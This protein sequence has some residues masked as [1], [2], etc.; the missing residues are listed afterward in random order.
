MGR[1]GAS[2]LIA[3]LVACSG[4]RPTICAPGETQVCWCAG[5][6]TSAQVCDDDGR[7]W[8]TCPCSDPVGDDDDD[9]EDAA[10]VRLGE[11]VVC[12][13]PAPTGP[14][15]PFVDVAGDA[16]ISFVPVTPEFDHSSPPEGIA[17]L[18]IE[19]GGGLVVADLDGDD[20]LD[21]VFTDSDAAP[22]YFRGDGQLGFDEVAAEEAGLPVGEHWLHGVS[23]ADVDADGDLDLLFLARDDNHFLWNRGDGTF[24]DATDEVELGGGVLRSCAGAWS[25]FDKDGDLDVHVANHGIGAYAHGEYFS[26]DRDGL[27]VQQA[28]GTFIDRIDEAYPYERDGYGFQGAWFDAD[29]DGWTDLYVVNDMA[30][31][32]QFVPNVF[33]RNGGPGDDGAW[34]WEYQA[35]S[36]LIVPMLAMGVGIGDMDNDMD[37]DVHVTQAGPTL[38]A[39]NDQFGE[40]HYFTDISLVVMDLMFTDAADISYSTSWFDHDND[41]WQ[42]LYTTFSHMPTKSV[43]Y[44]PSFT[45]NDPEQ[46]DG[47]W[48]WDPETE[49]YADL[50]PDLGIDDVGLT[51][52]AVV[53]DVNRDGFLDIT[54]FG[55]YSGP[56]LWISSCNANA[57][58][59]VHLEMPGTKNIDAIG[60][61]IELWSGGEPRQLRQIQAGLAGNFSGAPIEAHFGVGDLEVVDLV[62]LWPDGTRTVNRDIPT[63]REVWLTR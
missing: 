30:S 18:D 26:A 34:N 56:R 8:K 32:G 46:P 31:K 43:G 39:R 48:L 44:G 20:H 4:C 17:S 27:Y 35:S 15:L 11:E 10:E 33:I 21:L 61:E 14:L 42:E 58:L 22:H 55:I 63:R 57:W 41:G 62:V 60:A 25:D 28:D 47:F 59:I 2:L 40:A 12:Q 6:T 50:A 7:R 5:A 9:D 23:T 19:L 52:S 51:H 54:V 1:S 29:R 38:L 3:L 13:D 16:G 53:A 45:A 49:T 24:V 37:L 36:G